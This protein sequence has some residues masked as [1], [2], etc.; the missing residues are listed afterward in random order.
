MEK[1]LEL[2]FEDSYREIKWKFNNRRF[3]L[4]MHKNKHYLLDNTDFSM[5]EISDSIADFLSGLNEKK[6]MPL[7]DSVLLYLIKNQIIL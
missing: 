4:W 3:L 5:I 2:N 6:K 7:S 1:P